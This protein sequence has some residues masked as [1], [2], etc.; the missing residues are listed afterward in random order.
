[1]ATR[2]PQSFRTR[3]FVIALVALVVAA[4]FLAAPSL[5]DGNASTLFGLPLETALALPVAMPALVLILIWFASRQNAEE[6][7]FRDDD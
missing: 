2:K 7:R 5:A 4:A 1:M 6:A 3:S